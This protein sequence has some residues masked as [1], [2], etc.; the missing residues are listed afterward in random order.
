MVQRDYGSDRE[1]LYEHFNWVPREDLDQAL[2]IS[3]RRRSPP[4]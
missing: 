2:H 3:T 1:G 4:P